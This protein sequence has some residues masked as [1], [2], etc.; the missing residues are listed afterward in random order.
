[1]NQTKEDVGIL[2]Q[3]KPIEYS[4]T[5]HGHEYELTTVRVGLKVR[6]SISAI[7]CHSD[8]IDGCRWAYITDDF[9]CHHYVQP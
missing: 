5:R 3:R 4:H 6:F 8:E 1:M 7:G 2:L 9:G